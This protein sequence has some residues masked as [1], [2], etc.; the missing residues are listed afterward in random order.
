MP[1]RVQS[2]TADRLTYSPDPPAYYGMVTFE[3]GGRQMIDFTDCDEENV[4][5]AATMRMMFRVK[6]RDPQRGFTRYY[7]KAAPA[8]PPAKA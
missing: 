4:A 5:V 3:Q 7:W 2:Y 1:A 6:D 8:S